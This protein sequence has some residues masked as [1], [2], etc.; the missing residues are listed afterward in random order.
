[1]VDNYRLS[2]RSFVSNDEI[3]ISFP[4]AG[5]MFHEDSVEDACPDHFQFLWI[6]QEVMCRMVCQWTYRQ[7]AF[8]E[9]AD[10]TFISCSWHSITAVVVLRPAGFDLI[11]C[12]KHLLCR[13]RQVLMQIFC[14]SVKRVIET[15]QTYPQQT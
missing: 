14:L 11:A 12:V 6:C 4:N 3:F 7:P 5:F 2:L 9:A 10:T 1:M 15:M 13:I 8:T